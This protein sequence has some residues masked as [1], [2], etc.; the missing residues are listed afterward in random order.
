MPEVTNLDDVKAVLE[1]LEE[2]N[3]DLFYELPY[4][5]K[6]LF[7]DADEEGVPEG[8]SI[9]V[10]EVN[11]EREYDSYGNGYT[12]DAY[13]VFRIE[14]NVKEQLYLLP[15]AYASYD[16]WTINVRQLVTTKQVEKVVK[17]WDWSRG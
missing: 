10:H 15:V 13:V 5:S 7:V 14:D 11:A 4:L 16:G 9:F 2:N 8:W 6:G 1:V 3:P 12:E 17:S